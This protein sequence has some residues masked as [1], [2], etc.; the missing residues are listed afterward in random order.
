MKHEDYLLVLTNPEGQVIVRGDQILFVEPIKDA[1]SGI[2]FVNGQGTLIV[3]ESPELI[4]NAMCLAEGH[5]YRHS[6]ETA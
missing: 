3:E 1:G 2:V 4:F 6:K 5:D